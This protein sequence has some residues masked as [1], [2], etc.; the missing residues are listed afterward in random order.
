[1]YGKLHTNDSKELIK[2]GKIGKLLPFN[3]KA[4]MSINRRGEKNSN[5]IL[6]EQDVLD[7]RKSYSNGIT[8]ITLCNIY[9]VSKSCITKI[10]KR[11]TWI[12][13]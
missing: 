7:I 4:L 2:I 6:T 12:F 13:I 1:M 5:S 11:R 10:I 3:V 8:I 9:K